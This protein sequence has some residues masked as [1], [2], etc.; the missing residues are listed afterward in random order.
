MTKDLK[1]SVTGAHYDHAKQNH[2]RYQFLVTFEGPIENESDYWSAEP[3]VTPD[4]VASEIRSNLEDVWSAHTI[5]V[6]PE[7]SSI[8]RKQTYIPV[9]H[10]SRKGVTR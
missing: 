2:I 1:G 5:L 9:N 3:V 7:Q 6:I 8:T 10:P 4:M